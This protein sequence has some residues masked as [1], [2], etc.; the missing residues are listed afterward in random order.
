[1]KNMKKKKTR[2]ANYTY[3]FYICKIKNENKI[4]KKEGVWYATNCQMASNRF[5][6]TIVRRVSCTYYTIVFSSCQVFFYDFLSKVS[7]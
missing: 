3:I 6:Y 5:A 1:M 7:L 2:Q 4:T